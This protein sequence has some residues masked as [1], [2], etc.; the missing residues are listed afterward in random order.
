SDD[1]R[2]FR[3]EVCPQWFFTA[4]IAVGMKVR[5]R[6]SLLEKPAGALYLIAQDISIQG[7]RITLRDGRGFP[8]WSRNNGQGYGR[9]LGPGGR[10]K[11]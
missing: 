2:L 3:V 6:G 9:R 7:D 10:G 1:Q 11:K 8:L 5:V 4:D